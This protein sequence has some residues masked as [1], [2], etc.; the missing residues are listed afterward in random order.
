MSATPELTRSTT[1]FSNLPDREFSQENYERA[2]SAARNAFMGLIVDCYGATKPDDPAELLQNMQVG[3]HRFEGRK[4]EF[5][6]KYSAALEASL[7]FLQE[8]VN[9]QLLPDEAEGLGLLLGTLEPRDSLVA[10]AL[11]CAATRYAIVFEAEQ[12][13]GEWR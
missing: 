1:V 13:I 12:K 6:G 4:G 2:A 8:A 9:E 5:V 11:L 10:P 3:T 7:G